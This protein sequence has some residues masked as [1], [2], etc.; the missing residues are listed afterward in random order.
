[1]VEGP[2]LHLEVRVREVTSLK[3]DY[4]DLNDKVTLASPEESMSWGET[5][6]QRLRQET[7]DWWAGSEEFGAQ[8]GHRGSKLGLRARSVFVC[9]VR[10]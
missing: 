1:M 2:R 6:V 5:H 7:T 3:R 10:W 8:R 9:G 4:Q